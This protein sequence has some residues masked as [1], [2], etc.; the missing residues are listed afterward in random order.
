VAEI[1]GV[2]L[3]LYLAAALPRTAAGTST[4]QTHVLHTVTS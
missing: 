2:A 3:W 1:S 4:P